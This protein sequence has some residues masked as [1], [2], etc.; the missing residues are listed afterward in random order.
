MTATATTAANKG[1]PTARLA[2]LAATTLMMMLTTTASFASSSSTNGTQKV[3]YDNGLARGVTTWSWNGKFSFDKF[4]FAAPRPYG[5]LSFR[6]DERFAQ[7]EGDV[8]VF[9]FRG[10]ESLTNLRFDDTDATRLDAFTLPLKCCISSGGNNTDGFQEVRVDIDAHFPPTYWH[11]SKARQGFNRI[12]WQDMGTGAPFAVADVRIETNG[13]TTPPP[14]Q[15]DE[16]TMNPTVLYRADSGL[17]SSAQDWSWLGTFVTNYMLPDGTRAMYA[18]LVPYGGLSMHVKP[19][20]PSA[21]LLEFRLMMIKEALVVEEITEEVNTESADAV[22]FAK[23]NSMSSSP[24][25]SSSSMS[26]LHL[27]LDYHDPTEP[28][29]R[30]NSTRTTPLAPAL[31]A[32]DVGESALF[33]WIPVSL[34]VG[35]PDGSV[36]TRVSLVNEDGK[37]DSIFFVTDVAVLSSSSS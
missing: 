33:R 23:S 34:G 36:L 27:R 30:A 13:D 7:N 2:T 31:R 8:L 24:P 4:A 20:L 16:S 15:Q 11:P 21:K 6:L 29:W 10:N 37:R 26:M 14:Q 25:S 9:Q 18:H 19:G 5:A 17:T 28:S 3:I 12:S 1:K 22:A 35:V 32:T